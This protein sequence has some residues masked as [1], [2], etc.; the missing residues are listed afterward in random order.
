[1][2]AKHDQRS[3]PDQGNGEDEGDNSIGEYSTRDEKSLTNLRLMIQTASQI[4]RGYN[5]DKQ[6]DYIKHFQDYN[7]QIGM[8][9]MKELIMGDLKAGSEMER[10]M[11]QQLML[12][13]VKDSLTRT[14]FKSF[15]ADNNCEPSAMWR[16]FTKYIMPDPERFAER[17]KSTM[18]RITFSSAGGIAA[19]ITQVRTAVSTIATCGEEH[20]PTDYEMLK[21]MRNIMMDNA[22]PMK[23]YFEI[24]VRGL[25][26]FDEQEE[27][28]TAQIQQDLDDIADLQTSKNN[29][30][31]SN[32]LYCNNSNLQQNLSLGFKRQR[33]ED[34]DRNDE[35]VINPKHV[36]FNSDQAG[37]QNRHARQDKEYE[38]RGNFNSSNSQRFNN[39]GWD[40]QSSHHRNHN[41]DYYQSR[42]NNSSVYYEEQQNKRR[43]YGPGQ[44]EK[45]YSNMTDNFKQ[46]YRG[47]N[48][49][50]QS[51]HNGEGDRNYY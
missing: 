27:K 18:Q 13:L 28:I 35:G 25:E 26:S 23:N 29:G 46:D 15:V 17:L 21:F 2:A 31:N 30:N 38:K 42:Q 4:F 16:D 39:D 22:N 7:I 41:Q 49:L 43:H 51:A 50:E 45:V 14:V 6:E 10:S 36:L 3:S 19:A 37:Q 44:K 1:M 5:C 40:R 33:G 24:H 11:G 48:S 9:G 12:S 20:I 32:G 47:R 8:L 34:M